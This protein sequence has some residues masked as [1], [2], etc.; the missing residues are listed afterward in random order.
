MV[1]KTEIRVRVRSEDTM[2]LALKMEKCLQG[3]TCEQAPE[4]GKEKEM[5]SP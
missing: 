2:L 1:T 4:T 5:D 3:Q